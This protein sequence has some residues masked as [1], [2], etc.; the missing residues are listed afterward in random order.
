MDTSAGLLCLLLTLLH[1]G[2]FFTI[3]T[4]GRRLL[5]NNYYL[6]H[7]SGQVSPSWENV[8]T[9]QLNMKHL[10]D[11]SVS[12]KLLIGCCVSRNVMLQFVCKKLYWI[13]ETLTFSPQFC[14]TCHNVLTSLA[15]FIVTWK[16]IRSCAYCICQGLPQ[17][18]VGG[19]SSFLS[20]D[21][22]A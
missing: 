18:L 7:C 17:F 11:Y 22:C 21:A 16:M 1:A 3:S 15:V 19:C 14:Y 12:P 8:T 6:L 2:K 10:R 4:L 5:Y 13:T 9:C 20:D